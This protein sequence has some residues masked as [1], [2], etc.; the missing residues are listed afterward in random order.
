MKVSVCITTYNHEKY[1]AQAIES[2]LMQST[3]F[4]CEIIIGEDDS[5]DNTRQIV[6]EYKSKYPNK[7]R[8]F[9]N[10][11]KNVIYIDG[12]PTGRRNFVNN[13]KNA[14]GEYI[15]L[16]E[17]DDYWTD[18]YKLQKQ[19]NFLE[20]NPDFSM[21]FHDALIMENNKLT[22]KRFLT[23]LDKSVFDTEATLNPF[24]SFAPTASIL[25]RNNLIIPFPDWYYSCVFGDRMIFTMLS[26]YGKIKYQDFPGAVRRIHPGGISSSFTEISSALNRNIFYKN[27]SSYLGE[28][29]RPLCNQYLKHFYERLI[30]YY[31]SN[32][33]SNCSYSISILKGLRYLLSPTYLSLLKVT[34]IKNERGFIKL[35]FYIPKTIISK[36]K[37]NDRGIVE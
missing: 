31:F 5:A 34:S 24:G 36:L 14:K 15:A 4:D 6:K 10:D 8:L 28:K 32:Q 19:V 11:R 13:L 25:F 23:A 3:N 22:K 26:K 2:V 29:Y 18:P 9:L 33:S 27:M 16:L 7:I 20:A 37:K 1:I 35:I 17:G 12:Q 30:Q 21:C